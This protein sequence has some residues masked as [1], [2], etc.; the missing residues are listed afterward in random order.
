M[1]QNGLNYDHNFCYFILLFSS[2]FFKEGRERENEG[3]KVV[4][5]S[6]TFLFHPNMKRCDR[7]MKQYTS[8]NFA[9]HRRT[10]GKGREER[11]AAPPRRLK[12]ERAICSLCNTNQSKSNMSRHQNSQACRIMRE[13]NL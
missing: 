6:N 5:K 1:E 2:L 13:A 11:E 4:I 3:A 8:S 10:C 7:C 12:G 9:R